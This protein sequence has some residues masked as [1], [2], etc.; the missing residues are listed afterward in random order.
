[1]IFTRV[2]QVLSFHFWYDAN[3]AAVN[4]SQNDINLILYDTFT[5]ADALMV[6]RWAVAA[7]KYLDV[8]APSE[9]RSGRCSQPQRSLIVTET[10]QI[11]RVTF[12]PW[13]SK[14]GADLRCL[15]SSPHSS[16]KEKNVELESNGALFFPWPFS[17]IL[18]C[19]LTT[20][21]TWFKVSS[22]SDSAVKLL[23][24]RCER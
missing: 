19:W 23:W 4:I 3:I 24:N 22:S 14:S 21:K 11:G 5:S 8:Y 2:F 16:L 9:Q 13:S 1:M 17:P 18:Q 15:L 12:A 20:L 7:G 10:E 6:Y